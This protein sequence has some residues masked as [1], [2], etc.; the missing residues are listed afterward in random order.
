[1]KILVVTNEADAHASSVIEELYEIVGGESVYR[2]NTEMLLR[3]NVA[4]CLQS[5]DATQFS[6]RSN[7]TSRRLELG[8]L[9]SIYYRRPEVVFPVDDTCEAAIKDIVSRESTLFID[10]LLSCLDT[11]A[12]VL[13]PPQTLRRANSK[14]LQYRVATQ[15][16]FR[17]PDTLYSNDK[18]EVRR[19]A[20]SNPWIAVKTLREA[21]FVRDEQSFSFFT[22]RV[23][24]ADILKHVESA[25]HVINYLQAYIPKRHELRVTVVR[26]QVFPVRLESQ[27]AGE[28][29]RE[30]WRREN[31]AHI[32]HAVEDLP[33]EVVR[34]IFSF[35]DAMHLEFGCFDFIVDP[36]G[37]LWFLEC[38]ANGQ[39]LWIQEMTGLNIAKAIA[40]ALVCGRT[41]SSRNG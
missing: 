32:E 2:L 11:C 5:I 22:R 1:M 35:M 36:D 41:E 13:S 30:D 7:V 3:K 18:E 14:L 23:S 31:Y 4:T 16:G 19:F 28:K 8:D 25:P 26:R 38:N 17:V 29:A 15:C 12:Y 33:P 9:R 40:E 24:G 10:W 21:S 6:L 20:E 27:R 39:W 34:S 37:K